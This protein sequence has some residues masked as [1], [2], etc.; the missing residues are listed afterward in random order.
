MR[1]GFLEFDHFLGGQTESG[2]AASP[3]ADYRGG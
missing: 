3:F 1:Q 2:V